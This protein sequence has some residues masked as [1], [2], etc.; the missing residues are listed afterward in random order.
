MPKEILSH[1]RALDVYAPKDLFVDQSTARRLAELCSEMTNTCGLIEAIL[2]LAVE[3]KSERRAAYIK[4]ALS[5]SNRARRAVK[6][7][8]AECSVLF[9]G[10]GRENPE[11]VTLA[12]TERRAIINALR[13]TG[14]NTVATA[15]ILGIARTTL[16]RKRKEYDQSSLVGNSEKGDNVDS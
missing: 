16:Y 6:M 8:L 2:Q 12:E 9:E 14:G 3:N 13:E 5:L 15:G 10:L 7:F 4:T 11:P 1:E